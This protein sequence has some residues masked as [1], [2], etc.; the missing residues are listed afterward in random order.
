ME[1]TNLLFL[2]IFASNFYIPF[3]S[4]KP[5]VEMFI[6]PCSWYIR[7]IHFNGLIACSGVKK[8]SLRI[9]FLRKE[10]RK[11]SLGDKLGEYG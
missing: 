4:M 2:K 9:L 3:N 5:I 10:S 7:N 6:P 11:K 8:H 1:E